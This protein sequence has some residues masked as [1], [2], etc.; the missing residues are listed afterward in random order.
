MHAG[1]VIG[2]M[3]G[4]A[5][6]LEETAVYGVMVLE[7]SHVIM[8]ASTA[9]PSPY[10]PQWHAGACACPQGLRTGGGAQGGF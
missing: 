6:E 4:T 2:G 9:G 8:H 1:C 7:Q 10:R 3:S 5:S